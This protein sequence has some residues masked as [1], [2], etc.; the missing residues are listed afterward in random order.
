LIVCI[1]LRFWEVREGRF[2]SLL[3]YIIAHAVY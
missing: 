3:R 1:D 2:P